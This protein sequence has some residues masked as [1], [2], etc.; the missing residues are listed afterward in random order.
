MAATLQGEATLYMQVTFIGINQIYGSR[1][2]TMSLGSGGRSS[3]DIESSL[4]LVNS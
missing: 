4:W 1:D 3:E 2:G